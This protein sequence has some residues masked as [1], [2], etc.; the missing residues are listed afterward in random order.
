M[1]RVKQYSEQNL[2]GLIDVLY[3]TAGDMCRF[4]N[5][6]FELGKVTDSRIVVLR[7]TDHTR[8]IDSVV[9]ASK[10]DND[11]GIEEAVL[12]NQHYGSLHDDPWIGLKIRRALRPG[13]A[14]VSTDV[15][16]DNDFRKTEFYNDFLRPRGWFC[17]LNMSFHRKDSSVFS[18]CALR[19]SK[20]LSYGQDDIKLF[21][22]LWPHINRVYELNAQLASLNAYKSAFEDVIDRL[23]MGVL[24][25]D[26]KAKVYAKNTAATSILD[27]KDGLGLDRE[28]Q[29]T[30]T[31]HSLTM[32]I[33]QLVFDSVCT[34]HLKG[35]S[36]GGTLCVPRTSD[37]RDYCLLITPLKTSTFCDIQH[38]PY[39]AIF[40]SDPEKQI[41]ISEEDLC[42]IFNLSPAESRIAVR[43]CRGQEIEEISDELDLSKNTIKT[44]AKS[45]Y[46]KTGTSRKAGL[47][48][49]LLGSVTSL[50]KNI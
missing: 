5:F 4:T 40:I 41:E 33:R 30:A 2:F 27:A 6:L 36:A 12:Y 16:G 18:L 3:S 24:L 49:Q 34:S 8:H 22:A 42:S 25:V 35:T 14:Y 46:K 15:I 10:A 48:R 32:Q 9:M 20:E 38:Q 13:P 26:S 19:S 43:L 31:S 29:V 47:V 45:V 17:N 1:K 50:R 21:E 11:S 37:K 39:A 7:K 44:H 23:P 28:G